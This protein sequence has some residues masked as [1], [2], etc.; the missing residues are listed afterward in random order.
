MQAVTERDALIA[1]LSWQ[2]SMGADEAMLDAPVAR[3][4]APPPGPEAEAKRPPTTPSAPIP[5]RKVPPAGQLSASLA[6]GASTLEELR[7]AMAGFEGSAL[8]ETATN[9]VFSDGVPGAPVM[10]IG[11]APGAEEDRQG[12]PFVG[13]SGQLL[14]RMFASIGLSRAENLY[15][16][17]I[18]PFRPP[19]NRTPTDA[20]IALFLPFVLRHVQLAAPRFL[21]LAGGVSAKGVLQAREGITRLRGR[22]HEVTVLDGTVFKV[23]PTWHPAYLLR[24]PIAKRDAWADLLLLRRNM[25]DD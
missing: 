15:I 14:D 25:K 9:F 21:V 2:L 18:L 24:N 10:I 1:A 5:L 3:T 8:R 19:G 22:W 11:E 4:A 23:L 17:N 6:A 12:K 20:E 13:A 16:T 7:A